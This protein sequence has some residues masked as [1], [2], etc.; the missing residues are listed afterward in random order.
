MIYCFPSYSFKIYNLQTH[1][2]KVIIL[3]PG[4]QIA[5]PTI[6]SSEWPSD[7]AVHLALEIAFE[8]LIYT[9]PRVPRIHLA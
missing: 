3:P 4:H 7:Y 6:L 5:E 8:K 9:P 2:F 1:L